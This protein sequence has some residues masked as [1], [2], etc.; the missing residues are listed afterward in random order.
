MRRDAT[1]L[2]DEKLQKK[3]KKN[4]KNLHLSIDIE[5]KLFKARAVKTN[6]I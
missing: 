5:I 2:N 3:N 1:A 4:V 6:V